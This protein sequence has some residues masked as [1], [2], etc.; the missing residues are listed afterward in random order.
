MAKIA[1]TET[2]QPPAECNPP[3]ARTLASGDRWS[4]DD[5]LCTAGPQDRAFEEEHTRTSIALVI[6]GTFQYRTSSGSELMTPGS[7]LLGNCGDGYACGHEHSTGDRCVSFHYSEELCDEQRMGT[8][9]KPFSIPRIPVM[10]DLSPLVARVV[11]LLRDDA[12]A[13]VG[14]EIALQVLDRAVHLQHGLSA[15]KRASDPS[16][17]ARITRV[18]RRIEAEPDGRHEL[19]DL[20]TEARLSSFHFLRCFEELTGTTPHQYLLRLRLRR[21]AL[22]LQENSAKVLDIAFDCGFGDVS[23]FNRAFRA[24]FGM[25]PRAY[26]CL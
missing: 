9:R 20:A 5:V 10:R 3:K 19:S 2:A 24:E 8:R 21:A 17:L 18:L 11:N 4:I 26:R 12:D 16:A 13:A 23:N 6:G 7:L 22:K 25:S 14:Q 1:V 15:R